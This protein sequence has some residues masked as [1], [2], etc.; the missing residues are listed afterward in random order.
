MGGPYTWIITLVA[1]MV[2]RVALLEWHVTTH[3]SSVRRRP[4][5]AQEVR[6]AVFGAAE[7]RVMVGAILSSPRGRPSSESSSVTTQSPD[8]APTTLGPT[9][10]W[11]HDNVTAGSTP[12]SLHAFCP[13]GYALEEYGGDPE[14]G[15]VCRAPDLNFVC[16]PCCTAM[17]SAPWCVRGDNNGTDSCQADAQFASCFQRASDAVKATATIT[18]P[19]NFSLLVL[20]KKRATSSSTSPSDGLDIVVCMHKLRQRRWECPVG[21]SVLATSP[22]CQPPSTRAPEMTMKPPP[23]TK[24]TLAA[25]L[26]TWHVD[27]DLGMA[28]LQSLIKH[29]PFDRYTVEVVVITDNAS[30]DVVNARFSDAKLRG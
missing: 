10:V 11:I 24:W 16:P 1:L 12:L 27:A 30:S 28:A 19:S 29:V 25:V 20:R 15:D 13:M 18:C 9:R 6:P 7:R 3:H 17:T 21:W 14:H 8:T 4:G 2:T 5:G 26:R 23:G 22:F